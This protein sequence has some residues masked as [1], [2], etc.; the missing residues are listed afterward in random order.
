MNSC[1]R[2]R[3][4]GQLYLRTVTRSAGLSVVPM[5][6]GPG[7]ET[8]W[9]GKFRHGESSGDLEF[10]GSFL[11]LSP[12]SPP[13]S[14]S[15]VNWQSVHAS[16]VEEQTDAADQS[17]MTWAAA[18]GRGHPCAI[19]SCRARWRRADPNLTW[20]HTNRCCRCEFSFHFFLFRKARFK[21]LNK[22]GTIRPWTMQHN[23]MHVPAVMSNC[24]C[25]IVD[26]VLWHCREDRHHR[27][28][29]ACWICRVSLS[30]QIWPYCSGVSPGERMAQV[31]TS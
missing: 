3:A 16:R 29:L 22:L 1:E 14:S 30:A 17:S 9:R 7:I 18:N 25:A 23:P 8:K 2:D 4:E 10:L 28:G 5:W 6:V 26:V 20:Q 15:A 27:F 19:R 11:S 21:I 31:S 12:S 24:A 13:S